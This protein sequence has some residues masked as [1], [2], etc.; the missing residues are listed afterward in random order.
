MKIKEITACSIKL[1]GS[2]AYSWDSRS[3]VEE[4]ASPSWHIT[5]GVKSK[6]S[7]YFSALLLLLLLLLPYPPPPSPPH[8]SSLLP[9]IFLTLPPRLLFFLLPS[10]SPPPLLLRLLIT[11]FL[12]SLSRLLHPSPVSTSTCVLSFS[13]VSLSL[14][15][16]PDTTH[17][18][19]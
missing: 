11:S 7:S 9:P 19:Q 16:R 6:P 1:G 4:G 17:Q 18:I 10:S 13:S 5:L 12:A 14:F 2:P 8:S 3:R 15:R